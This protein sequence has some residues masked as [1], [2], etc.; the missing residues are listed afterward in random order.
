MR[1]GAPRTRSS[2][3]HRARFA[4]WGLPYA[5]DRVRLLFFSLAHPHA[6]WLTPDAVR[7]LDGWLKPTHRGIEWGAGRSTLW[8]SRRV[9]CLISIEHDPAWYDRIHRML[10]AQPQNNVQLMLLSKDSSEYVRIARGLPDNSVDFAL[11]DGVSDLRDLCAVEVLPKIKPAGLLIVDDVHRYLPSSSRSPHA[12]PPG[13]AAYSPVWE[14][15]SH[16]VA[17]WTV[18]LTSS[19]VTDT[20]IWTKPS[21]DCA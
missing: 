16:A 9:D 11:V 10:L 13:E 18:L 14:R 1:D 15:F 19:G 8:F 6:P 5:R 12:L 20:C 7:F 2:H 17:G 4:H 21:G 3:P